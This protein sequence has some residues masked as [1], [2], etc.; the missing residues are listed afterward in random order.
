MHLDLASEVKEWRDTNSFRE[1][2]D[3]VKTVFRFLAVL[4]SLKLCGT[5]AFMHATAKNRVA[6]LVIRHVLDSYK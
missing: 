1:P 3:E 4:R 5:E 6:S 2:A